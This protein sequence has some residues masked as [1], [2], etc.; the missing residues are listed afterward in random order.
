MPFMKVGID[1]TGGLT[2]PASSLDVLDAEGVMREILHIN[3]KRT[4]ARLIENDGLPYHWAT[5]KHRVF[6]RGEVM[7]W[8]TSRCI[9]TAPDQAAG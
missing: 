3:D 5:R 8:L 1:N 6:I 7:D 2:R 4:L 9:S